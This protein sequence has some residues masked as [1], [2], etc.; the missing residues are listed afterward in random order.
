MH[1]CPAHRRPG[2]RKRTHL[3]NLQA[4]KGE[5]YTHSPTVFCISLLLHMKYNLDVLGSC[6]GF[7]WTHLEVKLLMMAH[8]VQKVIPK[9]PRVPRGWRISYHPLRLSTVFI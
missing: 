5:W 6:W 7:I 9:I 3:F 1:I 8:S 2:L 4:A